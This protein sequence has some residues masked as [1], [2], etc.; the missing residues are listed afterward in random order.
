M[1]DKIAQGFAEL[2]AKLRKLQEDPQDEKRRQE[3]ARRMV[4]G[5]NRQ[6]VEEWESLGLKPLFANG[7]PVSVGFARMTGALQRQIDKGFSPSTA[8]DDFEEAS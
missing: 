1:N 3:T 8:A 5:T 6:I 7:N 2:S 4:A